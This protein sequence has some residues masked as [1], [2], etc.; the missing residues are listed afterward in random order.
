MIT[1]RKID[2]VF[3]HCSASDNRDHDSVETIRRWHVNGNGWSDIGYHFVI[4]K[5][6]T[7]HL[8]RPLRRVPAAQKGHNRGSIAICLTGKE[9]YD[10]E[11]LIELRHLCNRL[12]TLHVQ[13]LRFRGHCEV[14]RKTCPV[15]NYR[16]LLSLDE[17]G[18]LTQSIP[19]MGQDWE[20]ES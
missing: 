15:F 20:R 4:T 17:R 13:P 14:S 9:W 5:D 12:Q 16:D 2:T 7:I 11:Q 10:D 18:H 6:G 3:I 19:V 8:G 1:T